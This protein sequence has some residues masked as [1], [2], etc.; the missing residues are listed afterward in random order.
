MGIAGAPLEQ[1][2]P[3]GWQGVVPTQH[4][5]AWVP[6]RG[7]PVSKH[8]SMNEGEPV[9]SLAAFQSQG[10]FVEKFLVLLVLRSSRG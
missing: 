4:S 9:S 7:V 2:V 1:W 8:G 5:L 6:G 3:R 10:D